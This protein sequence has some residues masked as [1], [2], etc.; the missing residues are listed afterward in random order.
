MLVQVSV[1]V[2]EGSVSKVR[3]GGADGTLALKL[4]R[5]NSTVGY[6]DFFP[7]PQSENLKAA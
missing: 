2:V 7:D 4:W 3:S 5:G 1:P 6:K